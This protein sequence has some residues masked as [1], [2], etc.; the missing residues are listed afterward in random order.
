MQPDFAAV[1]AQ[2]SESCTVQHALTNGQLTHVI[3]VAI[4]E[5]ACVH[6][7]L[8]TAHESPEAFPGDPPLTLLYLQLN[9]LVTNCDSGTT[10]RCRTQQQ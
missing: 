3:D 2:L 4:W 10:T 7:I 5:E 9:L 8:S 6:H 1:R